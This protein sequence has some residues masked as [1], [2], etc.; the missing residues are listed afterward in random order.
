MFSCGNQKARPSHE[1]SADVRGL[2]SVPMLEQTRGAMLALV[3]R[4]AHEVRTADM[5]GTR[6]LKLYA[7]A[8]T[9]CSACS[10]CQTLIYQIANCK[11][12]C[13][14]DFEN[15]MMSCGLICQSRRVDRT[16]RK[17]WFSSSLPNFVVTAHVPACQV[18]VLTLSNNTLRGVRHRSLVRCIPVGVGVTCA[19]R[20][21]QQLSQLCAP[22]DR[23]S[24]NS[25]GCSCG[26][27]RGKG[28]R[29]RHSDIFARCSLE[30]LAGSW[31]GRIRAGRACAPEV[32]RHGRSQHRLGSLRVRVFVAKLEGIDAGGGSQGPSMVPSCDSAARD[33]TPTDDEAGSRV[34]HGLPCGLDFRQSWC[35]AEVAHLSQ[36]MAQLLCCAQQPHG[37]DPWFGGSESHDSTHPHSALAATVLI[38]WWRWRGGLRGEHFR[39]KTTWATP[40]GGNTDTASAP[41]MRLPER[42]KTI[43]E[44]CFGANR[45]RPGA[46]YECWAI[47]AGAWHRPVSLGC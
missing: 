5:G 26:T 40:R 42:C 30:E 28:P 20:L 43:N 3:R 12:P 46:V 35:R 37:D 7:T 27:A 44:P 36:S 9:V 18:C 24:A 25:L 29:H 13:G 32:E 47:L 38:A 4:T 1:Q 23:I 8:L 14:C 33:S 10:I 21:S 2:L 6:W 41:S 11:T 15:G 31:E 34:E 19:D 17:R 45:P 39:P 22:A 16:I